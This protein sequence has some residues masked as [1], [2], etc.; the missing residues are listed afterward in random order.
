MISTLAMMVCL[1]LS[2]VFSPLSLKLL[3]IATILISY[4]AQKIFWRDRS[5]QL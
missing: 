2:L 5:S 1:F 4:L 3:L